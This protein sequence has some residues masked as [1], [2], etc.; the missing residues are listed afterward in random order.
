LMLELTSRT[1]AV[2]G[3]VEECSYNQ[4]FLTEPKTG[5]PLGEGILAADHAD[6][7]DGIVSVRHHARL[8]T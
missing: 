6:F 7:T 2:S 4:Q 3:M 8:L 1:M 5:I